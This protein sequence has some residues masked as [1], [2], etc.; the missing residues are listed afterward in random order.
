MTDK[1]T[2][3]APKKPIRRMTSSQRAEAIALWKS[4]EATLAVLCKKFGKS[5]QTLLRLFER[6]GVTKG[7]TAAETKKKVEEAVTASITTDA[8]VI[9]QRIRDTKEEHYRMASTLAKLTWKTIADAQEKKEAIGTKLNDMKALQLASN[10]LKT[11]RE[12]RY[13]VLGLNEKVHDDDTP[14]PDLVVQELTAKQ[15][16]DMQQMEEG[17]P[18]GDIDLDDMPDMPMVSFDEAGEG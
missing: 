11:V 10:V 13:A 16:S 17:D 12:E 8:T 18:D 14:L 6:E 4:G 15:I 5:K 9:A 2:A 1:A 3:P 7:S